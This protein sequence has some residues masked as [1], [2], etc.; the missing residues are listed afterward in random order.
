V[1]RIEPAD[2]DLAD[3]VTDLWVALATGQRDHGSH[4]L[5]E[6]NRGRIREIIVRHTV[7]DT[8]LV[9]RDDGVVGFVIFEREA[10]SFEQDVARGIITNLY[11]RPERRGEGI[12][13]ALLSAAEDTLRERGIDAVALE[14]MA[15]NKAARRFYRR[16]GYR[17]HRVELEKPAENDTHSRDDG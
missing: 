2:T 7:D 9:A 14:V 1:V 10:G 8:L 13:S 12:G 15:D 5:P 16:A 11:V 4:L 6:E 17:A 3:A